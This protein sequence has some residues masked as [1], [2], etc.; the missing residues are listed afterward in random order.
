MIRS[1]PSPL[2]TVSWVLPDSV[3][4]PRVRPRRFVFKGGIDEGKLAP[5]PVYKLLTCI[6]SNI[7]ISLTTVV[8]KCFHFKSVFI[9]F[10]FFQKYL[11]HYLSELKNLRSLFVNNN[12]LECMPGYFQ[13]V[14]F[15]YINISNNNFRKD[16]KSMDLDI[17]R[18]RRKEGKMPCLSL[19]H[20]SSFVLIDNCKLKRQNIPCSL[21]PLFDEISRCQFCNK[22]VLPQ[23]TIENYNQC[24]IKSFYLINNNQCIPW[25]FFD[26]SHKCSPVPNYVD[27]ELNLI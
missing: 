26:C 17:R 2:L 20:L 14:V 10:F 21:W 1:P 22:W 12:Q 13:D 9:N 24:F 25:K 15:E 4:P 16:I 7:L 8:T 3:G 6:F 19:F 27:L 11:P 5:L 23:H 18:K